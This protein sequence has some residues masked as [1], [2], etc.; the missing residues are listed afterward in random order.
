[1]KTSTAVIWLIAGAMWMAQGTCWIPAGGVAHAAGGRF[2]GGGF[3]GGSVGNAG[4]ISTLPYY[5]YGGGYYDYPMGPTTFEGEG[6][7]GG[8]SKGSGAPTA[9]T[10]TGGGPPE[11]LQ[12]GR[13]VYVPLGSGD[14]AGPSWDSDW[15]ARD[16]RSAEEI[17]AEASEK[18]TGDVVA[19]L[20]R[21][22]ETVHDS[23]ARYYFCKGI[24]FQ[25]VESGYQVVAPPAGIEVA[26][27]PSTAELDTVDGKQYL[28]YEGVYYQP[29]YS[30]SGI[31]YKVVADPHQEAR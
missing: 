15:W 3:N 1:M 22:Y 24:F 6:G 19:S 4:K 17:A 26:Q 20:P 21:G 13:G 2:G 14:A 11:E 9:Y 31:V 30:G 16:P 10:G 28:V 25:V 7:Q 23:T 29:L 8:G 5:G 12:D 18:N 27:L